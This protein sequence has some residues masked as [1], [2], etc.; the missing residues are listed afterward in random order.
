MVNKIDQFMCGEHIGNNEYCILR[1]EHEEDHDFRPYAE[2]V[3][4]SERIQKL[5]EWAIA[6]TKWESFADIV[7]F[8][9]A[10]LRRI[11]GQSV[12]VNDDPDDL[13]GAPMTDFKDEPWTDPT[14]DSW[15]NLI[16][17]GGSDYSGGAL[18]KANHRAFLKEFEGQR[19][20][21]PTYGGHG[22][23]GICVRI[24]DLTEEMMEMVESVHDY[25]C[26]DDEVMGEIEHEDEQEAMDSWV[27]WDFQRELE[28]RFEDD[29]EVTD[30]LFDSSNESLA[31]LFEETR[32][33]MD[34]Y[35]I[36]ETDGAW[37]NVSKVA[38]EVTRE[39]IMALEESD[40]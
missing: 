13:T 11:D 30:K 12:W 21:C 8:R 27:V 23:Y 3:A 1:E 15:I 6:Q 26:V 36:H 5:I 38:D 4:E 24:K 31:N 40:A 17:F 7:E 20:V 10:S 37:I 14:G 28:K 9:G 35:W 19:G 25:P 33:A 18:G 29:E 22:S 16:Q 2:I 34:E 32:E 39:E